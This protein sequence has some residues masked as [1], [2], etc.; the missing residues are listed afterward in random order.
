V[1]LPE[2]VE[3][4]VSEL[5]P[6]DD[7]VEVPC[8][9]DL[10]SSVPV[11]SFVLEDELLLVEVGVVVPELLPE[12]VDVDV[13]ELLL[14]DDLVETSCLDEELEPDLERPEF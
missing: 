14:D 13:P 10:F 7:L 8:F 2:E 12:E 6:D 11:L 1:L 3:V 5:L 9:D 4:D